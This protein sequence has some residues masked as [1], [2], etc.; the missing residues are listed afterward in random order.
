MS[1]VQRARNV[2]TP[3]ITPTTVGVFD[4]VLGGTSLPLPLPVPELWFEL[5]VD[6]AGCREIAPLGLLASGKLF[7]ATRSGYGAVHK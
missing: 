1:A 3:R 6:V 7:Y 4:T 2:T 5:P